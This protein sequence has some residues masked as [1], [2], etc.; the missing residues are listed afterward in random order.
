MDELIFFAVII[1]FSIVESIARSRKA[2][3]GEGNPGDDV[4]EG[5][6]PEF[7]VETLP[8]LPTYDRDPSYDDEVEAE[9]PRPVVRRP[10][11]GPRRA[12]GGSAA[13]SS[14][15]VL[16]PGDL[17]QE[18]ERLAGRPRPRPPLPGTAS[19]PVPS[20]PTPAERTVP[21]PEG[22]GGVRGTPAPV[23]TAIPKT[24][25]V[26]AGTHGGHAVHLAH[27]GFGTDPSSRAPSREDNLD[28]LA[29]YLDPDAKAVR[30]QLR[31][32]SASELRRA[33]ILREVL[34][35]PVSQREGPVRS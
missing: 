25:P 23:R 34:G 31:S 8:E 10:L 9:R 35:A 21:D 32:G 28:P 1:F 4:P 16:L 6:E 19:Q 17:L 7:R 24:Q 14:S 29:E 2:K 13:P 15:E 20:G 18:L 5:L 27:L 26:P 11:E 30:S 12:G 22:L 3:Q 33:I